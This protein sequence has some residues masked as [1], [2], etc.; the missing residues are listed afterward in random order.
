M[1]REEKDLMEFK[2]PQ[3]PYT[4]TVRR[5][6]PRRAKKTPA[7]N[8]P[9]VTTSSSTHFDTKDVPRFPIEEILQCQLPLSKTSTSENSENLR[10]FLRIR[11]LDIKKNSKKNVDGANI[12][13]SRLKGI[14]PKQDMKKKTKKKEICLSVND[15][16]SV[17]LSPPQI[18]QDSR[19]VKTEVYDGFSHVFGSDSLQKEVYDRVMDPLVSDFIAGKSGMLAAM[20]PTGSGKT[21]TV[22]GC[23][24]ELGMVPR[25]LQKIFNCTSNTCTSELTRSYYVSIFEIYSERGK[26]ERIFD[27][28]SDGVDL[29][30]QQSTIKGLQEV[31]VSN[32]VEAEAVIARGMLK[33]ATAMTNS[34]SQSS[35]S[36]CIINI[37]VAP[38]MFDG[39]VELVPNNAVLTIVDLAGAEREKK[40]G[41]QTTV[42]GYYEFP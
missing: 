25:A 8:A 35:R 23:P 32:A 29:C 26:G 39:K 2:S 9:D 37:R 19:R 14:S 6:P 24:R 40:T 1:E 33:R 28:S 34:N 31:L 21:H 41:N 17:T 42:R 22:F 30:L 4:I 12:A 3:C 38:N 11:P 16:R 13:R 7:T 20:G 10:V 5:N 27:L 18:M 36:Q 15:T